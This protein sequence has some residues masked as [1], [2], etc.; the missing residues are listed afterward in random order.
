MP[1]P[2]KVVGLLPLPSRTAADFSIVPFSARPSETKSKTRKF[3]GYAFFGFAFATL[4]FAIAVGPVLPNLLKLAKPLTDEESLLA[5]DPEDEAAKAVEEHINNCD[6]ALEM[7]RTPRMR[8]SRPHLK[9]PE[10]FR[11][12]NLTGGT[13]QGPGRLTVPPVAWVE[14]GGKTL[15]SIMH[16]G[17][18]VCGHPGIVHGGLLATLLDEGLARCCFEALPNKVAVTAKLEVNYRKPTKSGQYVVLR[19]ETKSVEGRKAWVE[20]RIETLVPE[21]ETPVVLVEA[22][23]LFISPNSTALKLLSHLV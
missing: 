7:R 3:L 6:L 8:E 20:G 10:P 15:V 1:P 16:L 17:T 12:H 21:G 19:A 14:E 22:S 18:D 13:L 23:G 5:Y 9:L 4:G 11:R 2:R